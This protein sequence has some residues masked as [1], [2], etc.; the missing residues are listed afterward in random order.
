MASLVTNRGQY[1][2]LSGAVDLTNDTIKVML[3]NSSFTPASTHNVVSDVSAN[4]LSG[5]GYTGGFNGSGRKTL[6]SKTFTESDAGDGVSTF[7][8]ADLSWATINAGTAKYA[9]I[10]KEVTS[11][12][13]SIVIAEVQFTQQT[14]NGGALNLVWSAN[15]IFRL[16]AWAGEITNVRVQSYTATGSEGTDFNVTLDVARAADDYDVFP[17][18]GG[19]TNVPILDLPTAAGSDRTTT[20]FRV[21]LADS[22]AAGDVLKFLIVE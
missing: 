13:D 12:A 22:L 6:A 14:T 9:A 19:V 20:T 17:A 18:P 5:T 10:I 4:E 7:D 16:T 1:S 8:A 2:I 21:T 15:G 11:D 3:L